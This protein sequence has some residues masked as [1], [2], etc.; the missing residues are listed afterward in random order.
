MRS[1]PSMASATVIAR[2][3]PSG[4]PEGRRRKLMAMLGLRGSR[5]GRTIIALNLIGLFILVAGAFGHHE[6]G[7]FLF[8]QPV[9]QRLQQAFAGVAA[10][11]ARP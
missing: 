10:D 1:K 2:S 6:D 8:R 7:A 5:I 3:D 4:E 11:P 9:A